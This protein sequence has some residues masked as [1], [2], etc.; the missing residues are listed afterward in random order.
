MIPTKMASYEDSETASWSKAESEQSLLANDNLS[1][2]NP[3]TFPNP[4]LSSKQYILL[5]LSFLF[6]SIISGAGVFILMTI[7]EL[8]HGQNTHTSC[9]PPPPHLAQHY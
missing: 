5:A 8:K 7:A 9:I 3:R 6:I 2:S 4:S 1:L